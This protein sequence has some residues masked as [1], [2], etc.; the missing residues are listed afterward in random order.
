MN[1]RPPQHPITTLLSVAANQPVPLLVRF[2]LAQEEG[3]QSLFPN[4][5]EIYENITILLAE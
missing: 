5:F 2:A 4:Y 3:D 1:F